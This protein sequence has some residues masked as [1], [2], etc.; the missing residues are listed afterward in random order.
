VREA[1]RPAGGQLLGLEGAVAEDPLAG[2]A[3]GPRGAVPV[4]DVVLE[5]RVERCGAIQSGS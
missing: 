2:P 5:E 1:G 3:P 4:E